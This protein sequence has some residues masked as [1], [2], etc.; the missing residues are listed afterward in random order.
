MTDI[1]GA[2]YWDGGLFSNTPLGPAINA[3]EQAAGGDR[4]VERELI[5]VELFPMRG[6]VP[7]TLQDVLHRM[8]QLQYTSRLTLDARFFD[9][10]SRIVDLVD[11]V[12]AT[13][14][15]DSDVRDD[16]TYR[17]VRAY[18]RI[19]HLNVVTSSLSPEL[20]NASDFSRA[21]V[22]ARI[23]AGYD[24]AIAQG[25]GSPRAPGLR[26]GMTGGADAVQV[27]RAS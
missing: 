11:R 21:S 2:P 22:E 6:A 20:S 13:L 26:F 19:D 8:M 5:V 17:E 27:P 3:L 15:P 9:K 23:R 18:R 7:Q 14:P 1:D 24:D 25:I 10:I 4:D 12:D 16:P